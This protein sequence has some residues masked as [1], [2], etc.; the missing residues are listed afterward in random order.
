MTTTIKVKGATPSVVTRT[1][2]CQNPVPT[3]ATGYQGATAPVLGVMSDGTP[4]VKVTTAT[5][6]A[7]YFFTS[8]GAAAAV[9][10][11]TWAV[12]AVVEIVDNG[13]YTFRAHSNTGNVYFPSG[14]T[15]ITG[16]MPP[17]RVTIVSTLNADVAA[18]NLNLTAVRTAAATGSEIRVGQVQTEKAGAFLGFFHGGTAA[19][20]IYAYGWIGAA[21]AS[22]SQQLALPTTDYFRPQ[23]LNGYKMSRPAGSAL[24]DVPGRKNPVTI[25]RPVKGRKGSLTFLTP[26]E[27]DAVALD[28]LLSRQVTFTLTDTDRGIVG[29]DFTLDQGGFD[30]ELEDSTRSVFLVTVQAVEQ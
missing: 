5:V 2:Q 21:N 3:S 15:N 8:P 11:E 10:G 25:F 23:Q 16:P 7:N 26:P 14:A 12:S 29:I 24:V 27:A 1:N 17:T 30:V 13:T 20:D 22:A 28:V 4:C 9:N 18:G 19:A 6:S